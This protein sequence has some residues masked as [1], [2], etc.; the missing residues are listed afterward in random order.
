MHTCRLLLF[1]LAFAATAASGTL[2]EQGGPAQGDPYG[3]AGFSVSPTLVRP[4]EKVTIFLFQARVPTAEDLEADAVASDLPAR[5]MY[6]VEIA[7]RKAEIVDEGDSFLLVNLPDDLPFD[8]PLPVTLLSRGIRDT[9][10]DAIVVDG[11]DSVMRHPMVPFGVLFVGAAALAGILVYFLRERR[12]PEPV[13]LETPNLRVSSGS[14]KECEVPI[15]ELPAD[16]IEACAAGRCVLFAGNGLAAGAGYPTWRDV[17]ARLLAQL[18]QNGGDPDGEAGRALKGGQFNLVADFL[19]TR[20]K[21]DEL[22]NEITYVYSRPPRISA[23]VCRTLSNIEFAFSNVLTTT[24]TTLMEDTFRTS[25]RRPQVVTAESER[26]EQLLE[27][28]TFCIVKLYGDPKLS[29]PNGIILTAEEHQRAMREATLYAKHLMTLARSN[30]HLFIGADLS[31]I[32]DYCSSVPTFAQASI[33][34]FALVPWHEGIGL[35]RE[36]FERKYHVRLLPFR[37]SADWATV[38]ATIEA[39]AAAVRARPRPQASAAIEDR[40]IKAIELS[41]IGAFESLQVSFNQSWNIILGNNGCGK[42]TLLKAIALAFCANDRDARLQPVAERLLRRGKDRDGKEITSGRITLTLGDETFVTE[43]RRESDQVSVSTHGLSPLQRGSSVVLGFPP[44][45]AIPS[46][47]PAG[48]SGEGADRA[49]MDDVLPCL[50]GPT[51]QRLNNLKQWVVNRDSSTRDSANAD[52]R[53]EQDGAMLDAFFK[54]LQDFTPGTVIRY[55][56]VDP[57]SFSVLVHTDDGIVPIEQVS[58]GMSSIIGW[59]GTLVQRLYDVYGGSDKAARLSAAVS[60]GND[61]D[62][63]LRGAAVVLVDEI[64]AHLHPEWQQR[65]VSLVTQRFPNVQIIATTHSPLIV[66]GMDPSQVLRF[67]RNEDRVIEQLEVEEDMTMGRTDQVLTG[68]LFGLKT[69]L[70]QVTQD[71]MRE[72][73]A[74]LGKPQ[75]DEREEERFRAL[76]FD[77]ETRI[78]VHHETLPERRA[79][80]LVQGMLQAH[81]EGRYAEVEQQLI[82]KAKQL[83]VAA[84]L[85]PEAWR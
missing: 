53:R 30:V 39:L 38:G 33:T 14:A 81:A 41:N 55:A 75:R 64:D 52:K 51:D 12:Q 11:P 5:L 36:T 60:S 61:P 85:K 20:L 83:L 58:Q 50:L 16:L 76:Q 37:A 73:Q 45:R 68:S 9:L 2:R 78:P 34:H 25:P 26:F 23:P 48:R 6:A 18:Q 46:E 32:E 8:Q 80:E 21:R 24:W 28:D 74:L 59:I 71:R 43:I 54:V 15:P 77:L 31:T 70:D 47:N 35:Q 1:S 49:T 82:G 19:A 62:A 29:S 13:E 56:G 4:A 17:L 40:R 42:S 7:G 57:K 65:L 63:P 69:T 44:L 10:A 72:Y 3:T 79:Q 22:L 27:G 84:G 67:A 66:G